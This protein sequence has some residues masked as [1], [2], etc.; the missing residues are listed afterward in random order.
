M[1]KKAEKA[2]KIN[3]EKKKEVEIIRQL[4]RYIKENKLRLD[5]QAKY[6]F[7]IN[8]FEDLKKKILFKLFPGIVSMTCIDCNYTAYTYQQLKEHEL[9]DFKRIV[10]ISD[11]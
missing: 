6:N 8:G 7:I 10:G 11:E 5:L 3:I 9:E 4:N 1:A 2:Q